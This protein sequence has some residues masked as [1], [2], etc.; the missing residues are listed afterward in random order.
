MFLK[1]KAS[2]CRLIGNYVCVWK[3]V[4]PCKGKLASKNTVQCFEQIVGLCQKIDSQ[5]VK[6]M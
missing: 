1:G 5:R 3:M 6:V 2:L 4:I